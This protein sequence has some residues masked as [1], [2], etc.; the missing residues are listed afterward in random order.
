MKPDR[1][2]S[3]FDQQTELLSLTPPRRRSFRKC[4]FS[5][6]ELLVVI[7]IISIL[8]CLTVPSLLGLSTSFKF[9][10]PVNS[11]SDTLSFARQTAVGRNTYVWV[12]LAV[13]VAPT[14][15]P[16][17]AVVIASCDGTDPFANNWSQNVV[18]PSPSFYVVTETK[19]Y[20]QCQFLE[21]G[22]LTP[23]QIPSLPG[24]A[25]ATGWLHLPGSASS[26]SVQLGNIAT[27][28]MG[29]GKFLPM[30]FFL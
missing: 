8:S 25:A 6:I 26:Q 23:Q 19:S 11:L 22:A 29:N 3:N 4:G 16:L 12:A 18:L 28:S 2:L 7:V 27:G 13:P 24:S 10:S 20:S 15:P 30:C 17:S 21:A 9:S 1:Y 14:D 5:L